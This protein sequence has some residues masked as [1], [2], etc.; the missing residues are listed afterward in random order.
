MAT[1]RQADITQHQDS[2]VGRGSYW[3]VTITAAENLLPLETA[4][5]AICTPDA[6]ATEAQDAKVK[7]LQIWFQTQPDETV[8]RNLVLRAL[9]KPE[10]AEIEVEFIADH[11]W[12]SENRNSFPPL[13]IGRFWVYGSHIEQ[14]PPKTLIPLLIDAAQAFGSGTH[15]TTEGCL[16]ALSEMAGK[17][18]PIKRVLD[19]GCGSAILAIAAS[20]LFPAAKVMAAD[21]DPVSVRTAAQNRALNHIAPQQMKTV[22]SA[23]F[24]NRAIARSGPYDIILANILARPLRQMAGDLAA[25][26]APNGKLVLSGLL[27]AQVNWVM[28]AYQVRGLYLEHHIIIEDWSCLILASRRKR[29]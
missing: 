3:R 23:G 16:R 18:R 8:I 20:H 14:T 21:N 6:M 29:A 13:P 9:T 28:Q 11:D 27:N 25:Q 10:E 15:P 7:I 24:S 22:L 19:M 4:I 17:N 12:L 26:L 5:E 1:S 2:H